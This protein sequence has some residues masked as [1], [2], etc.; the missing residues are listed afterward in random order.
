MISID[1][2]NTAIKALPHCTRFDALVNER[3]FF[4]LV[5][6][7]TTSHTT[8]YLSERSSIILFQRAGSQNF[9]K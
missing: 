5:N 2:V 1:K 9:R 8:R 7:M 3:V 4:S 6:D